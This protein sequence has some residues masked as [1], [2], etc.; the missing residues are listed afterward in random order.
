MTK[1]DLRDVGGRLSMGSLAHFVRHLPPTSATMRE[2]RP[3]D[4]ER[5]AWVEGEANAQLLAVLIDELRGFEWL[6]GKSHSK[7]SL[8]RPKPLETP[9]TTDE[10]RGVRRVGKG[11]VTIAEFDEW[12]DSKG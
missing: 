11:A 8:R 9:W 7:G 5:L 3:Q 4:A 1:Y 6:Y 12:F 10:E 2:L